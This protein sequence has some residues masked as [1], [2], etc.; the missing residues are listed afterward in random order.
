MLFVAGV[1]NAEIPYADA[2]QRARTELIPVVDFAGGRAWSSRSRMS[3][4]TS[5]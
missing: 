4:T 1:V 2:L 5:C 3:G